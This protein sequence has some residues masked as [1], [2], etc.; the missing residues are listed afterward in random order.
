[1]K[2]KQ[3]GKYNKILQGELKPV[4]TAGSAIFSA[5]SDNQIPG[6]QHYCLQQPFS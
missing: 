2:H 5:D 1:M 4:D 3:R 6:P